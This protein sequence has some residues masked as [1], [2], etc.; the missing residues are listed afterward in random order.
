MRGPGK[1]DV[2]WQGLDG[3]LTEARERLDGARKMPANGID[4]KLIQI[5]PMAKREQAK[6]EKR[7]KG[8][9]RSS[10]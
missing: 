9:T 3:R 4:P 7:A 5:D 1:V 2:L 8:K 6:T 10:T